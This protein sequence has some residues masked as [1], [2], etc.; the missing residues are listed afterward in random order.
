MTENI[1]KE[2]LNEIK[3]SK[4][5]SSDKAVAS[6]SFSRI[7]PKTIVLR[8][9]IEALPIQEPQPTSQHRSL[10]PTPSILQVRLLFPPRPL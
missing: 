10:V 1:E 2:F 4:K 6:N 3:G 7:I 5:A 8:A 9:D